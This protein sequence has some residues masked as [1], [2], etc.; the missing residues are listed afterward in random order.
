MDVSYHAIHNN[1][2]NFSHYNANS[3]KLIFLYRGSSMHKLTFNKLFN[4]YWIFNLLLIH[5]VYFVTTWGYVQKHQLECDW[6]SILWY[7]SHYNLF[8]IQ[9]ILDNNW[10][11]QPMKVDSICIHKNKIKWNFYWYLIGKVVCSIISSALMWYVHQGQLCDGR[12]YLA[13]HFLP[14]SITTQLH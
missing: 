1:V 10:L 3:R 14:N 5:R 4:N 12:K 8:T 2:H 13:Y 11:P 7:K 6:K 9:F